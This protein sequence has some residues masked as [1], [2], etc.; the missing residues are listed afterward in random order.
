[1]DLE[2]DLAN[3]FKGIAHCELTV[4]YMKITYICI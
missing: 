4:I 3:L 1:M 2:L